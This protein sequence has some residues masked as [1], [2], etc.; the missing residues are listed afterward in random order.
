MKVADV[1][2]KTRLYLRD[3]TRTTLSDWE[4]VEGINDA[5]SLFADINASVKGTLFR[6]TATL[7]FTDGTA[8]L[9]ADYLKAERVYSTAGAELFRVFQSA[10]EEGEYAISGLDVTSGEASATMVYFGRHATVTSGSDDI[11]LPAG[12]L[13]PLARV[14]AAAVRGDITTME[15]L[16]AAYMQGKLS[17]G[18]DDDDDEDSD[19]E[20]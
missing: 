20:S 3:L 4:I 19:D 14:S 11:D 13:V 12:D 5:L 10:P 18:S 1:V 7:T 8:S 9:P 6:S 17:T 2:L 16:G 15:R